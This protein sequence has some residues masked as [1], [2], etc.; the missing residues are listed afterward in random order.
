LSSQVRR[1]WRFLGRNETA[2]GLFLVGIVL[3][4]AISIWG[5]VRWS[6][7]TEYPVL[8]VSSESMCE[9]YNDPSR[10]ECTLP[11]GALIVIRGQ[12]PRTIVAGPPCGETT[13]GQKYGSIIIFRSDPN[14]P[15]YLVVHRVRNIINSS[16]ALSFQTKGDRAQGSGCDP[17]T[18]PASRV[19]G[20][21]QYTVPIPY[22]G[23]A[24]LSVRGFMYDEYTGQPKPQ[25]IAV[26]VALI[27]ALFAFEVIEPSKK[28]KQPTPPV[29]PP[30][31]T[32]KP[33]PEKQ[34]GPDGS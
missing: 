31:P 4:A 7:N 27:V 17:W 8:V 30:T 25:G 20:V 23:Q 32:V 1:F 22:L 19:V 6:L 3:V 14:R 21:Y 2:K 9:S 15:D 12:D 29:S 11:I 10:S 28:K 33:T 34:P 24:I 26:I 13:D 5:L 18:I 16:G